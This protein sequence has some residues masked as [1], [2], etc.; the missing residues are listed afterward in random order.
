MSSHNTRPPTDDSVRSKW[1]AKDE[2][3]LRELTERRK[4]IMAENVGRVAVIF[5]HVGINRDSVEL[6]HII[7]NAEAIRDALAPFD[8]RN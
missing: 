1:T 7:S 6:D 5:D 3:A 2:E 4:R 8:S